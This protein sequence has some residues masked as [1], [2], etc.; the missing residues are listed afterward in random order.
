MDHVIKPASRVSAG[1]LIDQPFGAA[2]L[3]RSVEHHECGCCVSFEINDFLTIISHP[4]ASTRII[5]H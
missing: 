2:A 5:S 4:D 3:V 1:D